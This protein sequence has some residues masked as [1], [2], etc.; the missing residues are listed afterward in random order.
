MNPK[1]LLGY[2][3]HDKAINEIAPLYYSKIRIHRGILKPLNN[4]FNI[5]LTT[6]IRYNKIDMNVTTRLDNIQTNRIV[7]KWDE[8]KVNSNIITDN[9]IINYNTYLDSL[10]DI[11]GG[12][13]GLVP[14]NGYTLDQ[15]T[16]G[17]LYDNKKHINLINTNSD[18][19]NNNSVNIFNILS[20]E[21][22]LVIN[23]EIERLDSLFKLINNNEIT[24]KMLSCVTFRSRFIQDLSLDIKLNQLIGLA[25]G[26]SLIP[27][28]M[29]Y[30]H[31]TIY[32]FA[33]EINMNNLNLL[34]NNALNNNASD[35]LIVIFLNNNNDSNDNDLSDTNKEIIEGGGFIFHQNN[36]INNSYNTKCRDIL[37]LKY[38]DNNIINNNLY[39]I[40]TL[41]DDETIIPNHIKISSLCRYYC[42]NLQRIIMKIIRFLNIDYFDLTKELIKYRV[43]LLE[44]C[45]RLF[46][47]IKTLPYSNNKVLIKEELLY[48]IK[49]ESSLD[50][51]LL[52]VLN[53][54]FITDQDMKEYSDYLIII[55]NLISNLL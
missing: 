23:N 35:R 32:K 46:H 54:D 48:A 17:V 36:I 44:T 1:Q 34:L 25:S 5:I 7:I 43:C 47:V 16:L 14:P 21:G 27:H 26:F 22:R 19:I 2:Q 15:L 50:M 30:N 11:E 20:N 49:G 10:V 3:T 55:Q 12:P 24:Y 45:Q 39:I 53:S 18:N 29:V 31:G 9:N 8:Y 33:E 40:P 6:S 4:E 13:T 28:P 41:E 42:W 52:N 37:I 38:I 51:I